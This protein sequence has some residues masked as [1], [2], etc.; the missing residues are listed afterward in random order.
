MTDRQS[1]PKNPPDDFDRD[2]EVLRQ[3]GLK[4]IRELSEKL[5]TDYNVH[6]PGIT[7]LELLCYAITDLGYRTSMPVQDL[8]A[9]EED[10][11]SAMR[12][13][14]FPAEKIL[15][16]CPLSERDYRKLL[17][18]IPGIR[19]AWITPRPITMYLHCEPLH[20]GA[21]K[22]RGY[23]SYRPPEKDPEE[24]K[25]KLRGFYDIRILPDQQVDDTGSLIDEVK[26]RFYRNRNL[27][28]DLNTV[29]VMEETEVALC[30]EIELDPDA[31]ADET[32]ARVYHAVNRYLN[33]PVPRYTLGELLEAGV[34]VEKIFEGPVLND[35]FITDKALEKASP[36]GEVRISDLIKLIMDIPGVRLV[37]DIYINF[38]DRELE[39]DEDKPW[40]LC[41]PEDTVPVLCK[42]KSVLNFYKDVIPVPVNYSRAREMVGEYQKIEAEEIALKTSEGLPVPVGQYMDPGYYT[43]IQNDFPDNFGINQNGLPDDADTARK[44]RAKQLKGYLLFFDRVL[45]NYFAHLEQAK[46]LLSTN[47]VDQT[48]FFSEVRDL[49]DKEELLDPDHDT[50]LE[51]IR[52]NLDRDFLSRRNRFLNHLIA[53]FAER[54]HEYASIMRQLYDRENADQRII[55]DKIRFI[56]DYPGLSGCRFEALNYFTDEAEAWDTD[57][58]SG[59]QRR[60]AGLTGIED[61]SR[62]TL[63]NLNTEI[64]ESTEQNEEGEE[65]TVYQWK[66]KDGSGH[67]LLVAPKKYDSREKAVTAMWRIVDF[68]RE[69]LSVQDLKDQL[70]G[71][72]DENYEKKYQYYK[73]A[74]DNFKF[75]IVNKKGV[76]L[77]LSNKTFG[78]KQKMMD[79]IVEM[80]RYLEEQMENEGMFVVEHLLLAPDRDRGDIPPE[81]FYPVGVEPDCTACEPADPYSFRITVVLPGWT[82]R[83]SDIPFRNY[84]EKLIRT[85]TPAHI[86]PRICWIGP[87]QMLE[88]QSHYRDWLEARTKNPEEQTNDELLKGL[89]DNL[90]S[91]YTIYP[92]GRLFDCDEGDDDGDGPVILDQNHLGNL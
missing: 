58:I 91:L 22:K 80:A 6:D 69:N 37:R 12:E 42:K 85:E 29:A 81:V 2:Y 89:I 54:F 1:I 62:R 19:N 84:M 44:A 82:N 46:N 65:V 27:C 45:A 50:G 16:V 40:Y 55:Q 51:Q 38:C 23:L 48:Y 68:V 64:T 9:E 61:Y 13:K 79:A 8:I 78:T 76:K 72:E 53:R 14:F 43:S 41:I 28:E 70:A 32:Y 92:R 90:T 25:E 20:A 47:E 73:T 49:K 10:N 86:L 3:E 63:L 75:Y 56:R 5:W 15:P 77:A 24:S 35:G 30:A 7:M 31:E 87:D 52:E 71:E 21:L 33:P 59:L 36:P 67:T 66:I 34:P 39:P 88:F 18:D 60:I 74:S 57:N 4:Y 26:D 11:A 83:F 17:I